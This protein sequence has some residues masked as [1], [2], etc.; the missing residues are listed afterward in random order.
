MFTILRFI[1]NIFCKT[2][3]TEILCQPLP[4]IQFGS[5]DSEDCVEQKSPYGTNCSVTCND[6]FEIKGSALKTCGGT[7]N[8]AWSQKN[9]I[10]RCIDVMPPKIVCPKNYSI[11][12]TDNKSYVLLAKFEPLELLEGKNNIIVVFMSKTSLIFSQTTPELTSV[13][14]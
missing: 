2:N 8:G 5:Y 12:L 9:K 3:F 4:Q 7:R 13:F 14:G 6:G 11:E 10:P 1:L